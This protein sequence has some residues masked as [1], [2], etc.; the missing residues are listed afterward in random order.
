MVVS[1]SS[2]SG[3]NAYE[4]LTNRVG[5]LLGTIPVY[6]KHLPYAE[7]KVEYRLVLELCLLGKYCDSS[8]T[9]NTVLWSDG[10]N[11]TNF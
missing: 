6:N 8:S 4:Y 2:N 3:M 7:Q 11:K 5:K 10:I 1:F 9:L